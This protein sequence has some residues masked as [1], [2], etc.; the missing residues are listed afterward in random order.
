MVLNSN[1]KAFTLT[2]VHQTSCI[3][4][5]QQNGVA[6]RKHRH[7]LNMARALLLQAGLPYQF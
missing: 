5:P 2:K 7:L 6:E 3:N 1:L 4:T